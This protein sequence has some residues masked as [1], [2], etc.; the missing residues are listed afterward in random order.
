MSTVDTDRVEFVGERETHAR[1]LAVFEDLC[2]ALRGL[3]PDAEIQHVGSTAVTVA[4]RKAHSG[5]RSARRAWRS[6]GF[7]R[8]LAGPPSRIAAAP[9]GVQRLEARMAWQTARPISRS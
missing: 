4:I 7:L 9:G 6:P 2:V 8:S 5:W 3:L 1:V